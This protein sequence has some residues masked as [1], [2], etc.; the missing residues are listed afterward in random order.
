MIAALARATAL[1]VI[2]TSAAWA[3][4]SG[5]N[6][7]QLYNKVGTLVGHVEIENHPTLGKTPCRNCQFLLVRVDCSRC[8][9]L[10]TTDSEGD[11]SCRVSFG[12]WK[13]VMTDR[14]EWSTRVIDMLSPTQPRVVDVSSPLDKK[15]FDIQVVL[16]PHLP[17]RDLDDLSGF[18]R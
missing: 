17:S 14:R 12:R 10:L 7:D 2:I 1:T 9:L 6:D 4:S 15:R 13:V 11:Y 18:R 3:V 8:A 16:P 5:P